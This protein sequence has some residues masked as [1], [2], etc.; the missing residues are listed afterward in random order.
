MPA[1]DSDRSHLDVQQI[2]RAAGPEAPTR[3]VPVFTGLGVIEVKGHYLYRPHRHEEYEVILVD[4]GRYR[5]RVNDVP[6]DLGRDDILLVNVGDLHEDVCE[7]PLRYF[8][9][10]FHFDPRWYGTD[11]PELLAP[12]ATAAQQWVH[13]DRRVFWPLVEG[14]VREAERGDAMAPHLQDALLEQFFWALVR[15][16]P[17]EAISDRFL[18]LSADQALPTQLRRLFC[19]HMDQPLT[20]A[21]MAEKLHRS[22]SSLAHECKRLLGDSPARLFLRCRLERAK[23]LLANSAMSVKEVAARVGF[24]DPYHFSRAF[25]QAFGRPPSQMRQA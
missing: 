3:I 22:E 7:P 15:A 1:D 2:G 10:R 13:A 19:A 24:Q 9:L 16:L 4:R 6:L 14:I 18:D 5:C 21:E 8:G 25:K 11:P 20:V 23:A 17:E 12:A